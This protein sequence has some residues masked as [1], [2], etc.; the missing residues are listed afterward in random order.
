MWHALSAPTVLSGVAALLFLL[1]V[2]DSL[3]HRRLTIA[4][5]VRLVVALVF[6]LVVLWLR[7]PSLR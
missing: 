6:V 7:S 2:V 1:A 5:Q 3:R 4:A